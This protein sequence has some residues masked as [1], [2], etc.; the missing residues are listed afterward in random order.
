[1]PSEW[2]AAVPVSTAFGLASWGTNV[3]VIVLHHSLRPCAATCGSARGTCLVRGTKKCSAA[4]GSLI[5]SPVLPLAALQTE[6]GNQDC[7][8]QERDHRGRDGGALAEI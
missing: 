3:S 5:A 7:R 1:M 6:P 2:S 4:R 8:Q